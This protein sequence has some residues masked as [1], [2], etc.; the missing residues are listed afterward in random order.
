MVRST[1][2]VFAIIILHIVLLLFI[3]TQRV[4]TKLRR[5]VSHPPDFIT[6]T[7]GALNKI[8]EEDWR[9]EMQREREEELK[10]SELP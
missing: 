10:V 3:G 1:K 6:R 5:G 4:D 7:L 9:R 2:E 8:V